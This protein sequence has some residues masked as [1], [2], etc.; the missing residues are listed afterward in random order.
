MCPNKNRFFVFCF[1]FFL[2]FLFVRS[3]RTLLSSFIY[4]VNL[5]NVKKK[6]L[7]CVVV[8]FFRLITNRSKEIS[9]LTLLGREKNF[10]PLFF[11]LCLSLLLGMGGGVFLEAW[12]VR[13]R[14]RGGKLSISGGR[15]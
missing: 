9:G 4:L 14:L 7:L 2:V 11:V 8:Y 10:L 13:T 1:S 15:C 5:E 3:K 12:C 6:M